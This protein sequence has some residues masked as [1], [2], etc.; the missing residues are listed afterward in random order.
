MINSQN[1]PKFSCVRCGN[2]CKDKNTIVNLTYSD[3]LRIKNG[4]K[5]SLDEL[6]D[7]LGFYIFPSSID[8]RIK[9]RL[10]IPPLK[11]QKGLSFVGLMKSKDGKCIF[12]DDKNKKCL[13]YSIRPN[14]CRTFPFT[15]IIDENDPEKIRI[16][17]TEKGK[18]YCLGLKED[19]PKI[20]KKNW[21]RLGKRVL[22]DL[23]INADFIRNW[24][25]SVE[26]DKINPSVKNFLLKIIKME[27]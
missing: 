8:K 25:I 7:I 15:F 13:I 10:V 5:L 1:N 24:N 16:L 19:A 12:Y 20:I 2:C 26:L 9:K 22:K 6:L 27:D 14:F 11:T 4:L 21:L 3:I 18:D 17:I 23:K